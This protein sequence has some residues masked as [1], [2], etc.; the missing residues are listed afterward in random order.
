MPKKQILFYSEVYPY[1]AVD[2]LTQLDEAAGSDVELCISSNGGYTTYAMGMIEKWQSFEGNK[3]VMVHGM[4]HSVMALF[5]CFVSGA[6]ALETAS[7]I[8]HRGHYPEWYENSEY[9]S[10][11]ERD[12]LARW[13]AFARKSFEAKIDSKKFEEIKG[14]SLKEIFTSEKVI[15]VRLTALEAKKVRLIDT[16]VKL[17]PEVKA[18]IATKMQ[19][20]VDKGYQRMVAMVT[21]VEVPKEEE[22]KEKN[23]SKNKIMTVEEFKAAHPGE[24]AKAVA[25][26]VAKERDRVNAAMVY[27][28]VDPEGVKAIIKNGEDL[29]QTQIAEFGR[30]IQ[31]QALKGKI[32]EDSKSAVETPAAETQV[33]SEAEQKKAK[34]EDALDEKLGLSKKA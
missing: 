34:F 20:K 19:I 13:N 11:D 32:G 16:V 26:G 3:K 4:A 10:Q 7:I 21:E 12:D 29:T 2:F 22:S 1:S 9:F 25:T 31:S 23:N 17:T 30:K 24:Y 33:V 5:L 8:L 15:D 28:D 6:S 27:N 14:I 18:E